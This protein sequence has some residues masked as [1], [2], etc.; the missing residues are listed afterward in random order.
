MKQLRSTLKISILAMV[1]L[2]SACNS[3][4]KS[5]DSS[6]S[7]A[8]KSGEN[9]I[10]L[11]N[12]EDL[13]DWQ[14]KFKGDELGVNYNNTFRVEDGLLSVSYENWDEWN[15][16]FGHIFYKDEFSNYKLHVVYRFVGNQAKSGPGWAFRNNGLMI[17]GQSAESMAL[18]QD[19]PTSIEVQLLG[20]V[21]GKGERSTMNLCTPGTNVVMNDSLIEQHCI[22]S[23]SE[24]QL[25]DKWVDV[26]VEV[27]GGEVIRHFVDGVE[28][29]HY[30]QPQLDPRD[31]YYDKMLPL[32]GDKMISKGTISLQAESSPTQFKTVEVLVLEE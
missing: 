14:I 17:H 7:A 12:G 1:V 3:K 23:I 30:E 15:G 22:N 27:H 21:T 19:F 4:P 29:M 11:F 24:T 20:G 31:Q 28:V 26:M 18:D 8:H 16:K 5:Q 9:W 13:N 6:E 25:D 32:Y 2:I 10:Q